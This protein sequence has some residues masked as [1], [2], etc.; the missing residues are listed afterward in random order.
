M[1]FRRFLGQ[2]LQRRVFRA[3]S[4]YL[5]AVW[6]LLQVA[7]TLAGEEIIPD[8]WVQ[9]LI[10]AGTLGLPL[11]LLGSW[12]LE[13]PWKAGG[14]VQTAGDIF[15]IAAIAAGAVLFAR[16]QWFAGTEAVEIAV[17]RIEA[18][19]LQP[20]TQHLA[21]H[22]QVRFEEL[23]GATNNADLL[24]SG[25]LARGGDV[26]RLTMRLGDA[27]GALLW[28]ETF[29]EAVVDIGDLQMQF[30]GSLAREM[31]SLR[32]R[33]AH[34]KSVLN[35]CPY[36]ASADAILA[37]VADDEAASLEPFVEANTENGLLYLEQ[38]LRWYEAV[39][40]APPPEKPVLFSMA[41]DSLDKAAAACPAYERIDDIRAAF[42]RLQ[43]L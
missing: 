30:I 2:L 20:V 38:S 21:D 27:H 43:T 5:A 11:V 33:H 9:V 15:I 42:S 22:L 26:L 32:K 37:M 1:S 41:V 35:A 17:G 39:S 10:F 29:E 18:T 28:S 40:A 19:D 8:H 6:I 13:A 4:M 34:A 7:D 25:T 3:A 16:Q 24:L 36:P 23:L 31:A 12:F 14:R